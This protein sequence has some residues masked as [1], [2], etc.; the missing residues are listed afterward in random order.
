MCRRI[1][2]FELVMRQNI[3][4]DVGC[5]P[6]FDFDWLVILDCP[7]ALPG[8]GNAQTDCGFAYMLTLLNRANAEAKA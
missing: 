7:P 1:V 6:A 4:L 5:E 3:G 2:E 8:G